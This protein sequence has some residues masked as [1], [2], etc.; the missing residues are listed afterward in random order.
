[1]AKGSSSRPGSVPL[2]SQIAW[3]Q[4][5]GEYIVTWLA[6]LRC[7][8]IICIGIRNVCIISA[9]IHRQWRGKCSHC[10]GLISIEWI[11][12]LTPVYS[13]RLE[14]LQTYRGYLQTRGAEEEDVEDSFGSLIECW[15]LWNLSTDEGIWTKTESKSKTWIPKRWYKNGFHF[16]Q[17]DGISFPYENKETTRVA[18][19]FF[20]CDYFLNISILRVGVGVRAAQTQHSLSNQDTSNAAKQCHEQSEF[21]T[22]S[23]EERLP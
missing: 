8:C 11:C 17:S 18:P 15:P 2:L 6:S 9:R 20:F 13:T 5:V 10:A 23:I 19:F 21:Y 7:R 14:S 3:R 12:Y 4:G 1:M 22:E 16:C